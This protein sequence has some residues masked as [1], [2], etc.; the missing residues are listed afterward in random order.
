MERVALFSVALGGFLL[1][2]SPAA[3]ATFTP[4]AELVFVTDDNYPPYLFRAE[5]GRLQ[6]ILKDRWELWSR[7]TGIPVRVDGMEW[8]KAQESVR[9]GT[10]DVVGAMTYT[11][12]RARLYEFSAQWTTVEARI[13]FH[14]TISGINDYASLRGFT[15]GAKEGSACA[16]WLMKRGVD[17]VRWFPS[18][19][20]LVRAAGAGEV[21]LFCMDTSTAQYFLARQSLESEFRQ[22]APLYTAPFHWAVAK[23]RTE[24]RDFIQAGYNRIPAEELRKIDDRWLGSP[25]RVPLEP[26]YYYYAAMLAAA[27]LAGTALLILWNRTLRLRVADR[28]AEL[29]AQK[30]VLEMVARGAPLPVTLDALLRFIE[31]Q[32]PGMLCSILLLDADGKRVRHGAAPSLPEAFSEAVDGEPIGPRAGS[33]GTAAFRREQVIT[34]DIATDPLWEDYR[35]LAAEHGLRACWSTP[36]LDA[37][38]RVLGTF[39]MYFRQPRRPAPADFQLIETVIQTAAIAIIK[40]REEDALRESEARVRLAVHASHIG[41]WDWDIAGNHLY[42][43]PEWKSQLGYGEDEI[44]NTYE[45]WR[46]RLHPED[47]KQMLPRVKAY[48]ANPIGNYEAEYRLRHKDGS[49][50][51]IYARAH[52]ETNAIGTPQRMIGCHIDITERKRVEEDLQQSFSRLQELSRRLVEVEEVERRNI[53]REL[54]DR[55]GQNLSALNL[56]L[57]MIRNELTG[58]PLHAASARLDDARM[59]LETTS[60][61]VRDVMAELR[62]AALDD[63]GLLAALRHHCAIVSARLGS[64]IVVEGKDL[65]PRLPAVIETAL[66]RIVQEALNNIAKHARARQVKVVLTEAP[67]HVRLTVSDDGV[68]FDAARPAG[69]A[70]TY[71]IVTMHERAEAVGACLRIV[72]APGEGTRVEVEVARKAT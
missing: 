9:N 4:P 36:I 45:E 15:L 72:S 40:Q 24:L 69:N 22:T 60:K 49:Y 68:G 6:G 8:V 14:R 33:C 37:Q 41:L 2:L 27:I 55:V 46:D 26:R 28:T 18:S 10:A 61:Q 34:E 38:R 29:N 11:E 64:A 58:Q 66:F 23:D 65:N 56:S 7:T 54:H 32:S 5:D 12:E 44:A 42:Y 1:L 39:A 3:P 25:V 50:R 31:A 53:N 48:L 17:S 20:T 19:E 63:Y 57:G 51:W 47:R 62:P 43:S 13:F 21:R 71:G 70:P 35:D 67:R 59:L 52:V 30:Q 16:S